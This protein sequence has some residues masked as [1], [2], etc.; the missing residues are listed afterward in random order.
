[1]T[2][3]LQPL[4][5]LL[6]LLFIPGVYIRH[7]RKPGNAYPLTQGLWQGSVF[8]KRTSLPAVLYWFGSLCFWAGLGLLIASLAGPAKV[9][10]EKQYLEKGMD[11]ALVLDESPSM[12]AED[13]GGVRRFDT[14]R[15][16]I[17]R[18]VASR[19]NDAIG[20]VTFGKEA[21]L[22]VPPTLDYPRLLQTVNDLTLADLGDG[23]AIGLGLAL[24]C[25]H[26]RKGGGA[27]QII[28]LITDGEQ[29]AGEIS[30]ETAALIADALSI[31]VYTIGI[32]MKGQ[33]PLEYRD[34]ETGRQYRG[35]FES[36]FN[37]EILT[38]I[39]GTTGARYY[40]ASDFESLRRAFDS[41]GFREKG[42]T[43]FRQ[44]VSTSYRHS[45]FILFGLL[46]V[47]TDVVIRKLVLREVLP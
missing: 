14:A 42:N 3:F 37:E 36:G 27:K 15:D 11:I 46:L 33:V 25:N 34:P 5:F 2:V 43:S 8:T 26:L 18:F 40:R 10:S 21:A 13:F 32:G 20:L 30:P 29:N 24:A 6:L 4:Y 19:E 7:V 31:A 41:I 16:L 39:A 47:L 12:A 1:M 17:K 9:T 35:T 38:G 23:T 22:R 45:L 44:L 28:I